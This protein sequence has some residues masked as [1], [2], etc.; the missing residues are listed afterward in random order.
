MFITHNRQEL[1]KKKNKLE[2][3]F[4]VSRESM[5]NSSNTFIVTP[6]GVFLHVVLDHSLTFYFHHYN[7]DLMPVVQYLA[8]PPK[9]Q[10]SP[11][12]RFCLQCW[13]NKAEPLSAW[14]S[15]WLMTER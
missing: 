14:L 10:P 11:S 2:D 12:P 6:R 3:I 7:P 13:V 4:L 15:W 5:R 8:T 1:T 9:S